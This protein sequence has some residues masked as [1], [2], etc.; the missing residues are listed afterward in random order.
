MGSY[1]ACGLLGWVGPAWAGRGE[2]GDEPRGVMRN[3]G[4]FLL[5]A[6]HLHGAWDGEKG[7]RLEVHEKGFTSPCYIGKG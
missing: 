1:L 2:A 6:D 7:R 5:P 4:S 3:T